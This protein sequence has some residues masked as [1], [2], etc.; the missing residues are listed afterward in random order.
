N[1]RSKADMIN[2][3][4]RSIPHRHAWMIGDRYHDLE[5]GRSTGCTVVAASYGYGS[6]EEMSSADY[7]LAR[8]DDLP[9]LVS[10]V[11]AATLDRQASM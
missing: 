3:L 11:G 10:S 6:A 8:I 1:A 5:A 2:D 4:R 7:H 9:A